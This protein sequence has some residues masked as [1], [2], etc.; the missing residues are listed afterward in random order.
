MGIGVSELRTRNPRLIVL[1]MPPTGFAGDWS[2]YSGFGT[3]FDG[4]TGLLWICG[5]RDS[6]LTTS[7]A[8][9]YMDAASGPA[10]AFVAIAALRYRDRTGRGQ[11]VE[12]AQSENVL[13]HLGDIYVDCELGVEPTRMG[14]RDPWRAPQGLYP[15]RGENRWLAVSVGDNSEWAALADAMGRADLVDDDR[16]ADQDSR[17]ANHDALDAIIEAWTSTQDVAEAFHVLQA[18][19]VPAAP[20][21]DDAMFCSDPHIVDRG[22]MR[23]LLTTD[24]G[25]HS[26]P[27]HPYRGVPEVWRR[28]SPSLGEDN[29]YVYKQI[30]GVSDAEFDHYREERILA[31]DYLDSEGNPF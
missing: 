10:A 1:R 14:N 7:P 24:V 30:L 6:D 18:A 11:V 21:M 15:G 23:P 4:L 17:M 8:T 2:S 28:G 22:W 13:N 20:L 9:T 31:E 12:L 5:H 26:H 29:E 25:A 16:F 19:G 3:Q 27:S